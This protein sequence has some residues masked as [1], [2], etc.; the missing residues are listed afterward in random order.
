MRGGR[1]LHVIRTQADLSNALLAGADS[2]VDL[3]G[4][5]RRRWFLPQIGRMGRGQLLRSKRTTI[6][7]GIRAR[8]RA[9]VRLDP[10]LAEIGRAQGRNGLTEPVT[11]PRGSGHAVIVGS[12]FRLNRFRRQYLFLL[13]IEG[14]GEILLHSHLETLLL[15]TRRS[16]IRH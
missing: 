10:Y 14:S 6:A 5:H 9:L 13:V 8:W 2:K 11:G 4:E 16:P 1:V 12:R 3:S 15:A 7:V